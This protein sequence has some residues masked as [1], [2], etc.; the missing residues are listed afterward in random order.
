MLTTTIL[1]ESKVHMS[2]IN[3]VV[4]RRRKKESR[5]W[6]LFGGSTTRNKLGLIH[7]S[8]TTTV[9]VMLGMVKQSRLFI[10][11]TVQVWLEG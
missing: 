8:T 3:K 5:Q 6:Y 4:T 10:P 9:D 2:K 7:M 1:F 11:D